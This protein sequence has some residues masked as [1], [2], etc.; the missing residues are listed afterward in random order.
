MLKSLSW[1]VLFLIGIFTLLYLLLAIIKHNHFLSGYDLAIV[2]QVMWKYAHFQSPITTIHSYAFT[3]IMTDHIEF[4]YLFLSPL[5]WIWGDVRILIAAQTII[6]CFSGIPIYLLARKKGLRELVSLTLLFSYLFFFGVQNALWNDVHSN[7]FGTACIAWMIY[8]L[9]SGNNL[10]MWLSFFFAITAKEDIAFIT[11]AI[12]AVWLLKNIKN[13]SF[14]STSLL[15]IL[16]SLIYLF[17][18][19]VVYFPH[20]TPQGYRFAGNESL[21]HNLFHASYFAD[22]SA[23][24]QIIFYS[25]EWF[26]FLPLLAPLYLFPA[27]ADL[28]H[29][30]VLGHLVES[31]SEIFLHYRVDLA[32][33]LVWPTIL[34]LGKWKK[35]QHPLV[36]CYLLMC[37]LIGQYTLHL[38]L[39]YLTK[40]WFWHTSQSV[41]SINTVLTYLPS[42][43]SVVSQNNITPHIGHRD[44]I[45]TLWG[46]TRGYK[47]L[48]D[49]PCGKLVCP[50][51][52][53]VGPDQIGIGNPQY[54]IVDTSSDWDIRH[55]LQN[56]PDFLDALHTFEK[57][58][59]IKI[60][61]RIGTTTLYR[62]LQ[63]P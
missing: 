12:G 39:S 4:I 45:F 62:V 15:L 46:D 51:F 47:N 36:I 3:N 17:L 27:I 1:K 54:M 33:L 35:L 42:Q 32:P 40:S 5:F 63:K 6:F 23:K 55:L 26:G 7:V 25:L 16:F 50:W 11:G 61:K 57:L 37:A 53:W 48:A 28:F 21:L 19:F 29:Y 41:A 22:T 59:K 49:S 10:W 34:V 2:D 20:F 8:F 38:P 58:G 31:A 9:E 14:W 24:R 60:V 30:F 44:L 13:K 43:A 56:R 18:I 52:H